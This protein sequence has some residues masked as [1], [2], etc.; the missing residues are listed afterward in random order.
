MKKIK[1]LENF[2]NIMVQELGR[3]EQYQIKGG[4]GIITIT[5]LDVI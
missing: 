5:D 3:E 4:S 1:N 2:K